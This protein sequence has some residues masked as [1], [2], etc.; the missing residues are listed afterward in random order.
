MAELTQYE[1]RLRSEELRSQINYHNH[2]YYV[3]DQPEVADAEYDQLMNALRALE[4]QF[5]E[6]ITPD[7]PTQ[8]T[9]A[10]PATT[11]DVVEH[12]LPLLSL[13]NCFSDDELRA[14]YKRAVDRLGADNPRLV[15]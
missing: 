10:A 7:S 15:S 8:R 2:R 4:R 13:S 11:F 5:P 14:W 9:G 1:A 6:L 12:R 3:L